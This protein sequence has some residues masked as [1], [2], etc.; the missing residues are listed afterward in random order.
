MLCN[1]GKPH[2]QRMKWENNWNPD[3]NRW[4]PIRLVTVVTLYR[5]EY[6]SWP[7]P[8]KFVSAN[9]GFKQRYNCIHESG[10]SSFLVGIDMETN[11]GGPFLSREWYRFIPKNV[12]IWPPC[13]VNDFH[14]SWIFLLFRQICQKALYFDNIWSA[15]PNWFVASWDDSYNSFALS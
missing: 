15:D 1:C 5:L 7:L 10:V 4:K 12:F 3:I 14:Q 11:T 9:F 13:S 2:D 8:I 6:W